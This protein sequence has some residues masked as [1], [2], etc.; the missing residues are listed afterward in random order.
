MDYDLLRLHFAIPVPLSIPPNSMRYLNDIP[1]P[2]FRIG[3]YA[4]NNKYILKIEAG[5]FEQTY[6]ISEIDVLDPSELPNMVDETFLKQVAR[7]FV[8]M[9]ADWQATAERHELD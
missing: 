6:K 5:L 4:W 3:L 1:H 9:G 2:H 7:R 8:D